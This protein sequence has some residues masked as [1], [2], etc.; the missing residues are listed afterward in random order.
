MTQLKCPS[1]ESSEFLCDRDAV[2]QV[3]GTVFCNIH[4]RRAIERILEAIRG[5]RPMEGATTDGW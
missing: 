2:Y 3:D 5:P 1:R 4:A